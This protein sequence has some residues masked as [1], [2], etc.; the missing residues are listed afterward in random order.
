[1][2]LVFIFGSGAVG[3]M[4][5]G[6]ELMKLTGLRLFHNHMAIEPVL[7]V[8][9]GFNP[10]AVERIREAIFEEFAA[11]GQKGMIFTFMF[12]FDQQA[13]WDYVAHVQEIFRP[14]GT[15]FFYVELIAP[16]EVRL[17][18]SATENR[19]AHKASKQDVDAARS[20]LV[21]EDA[22]YRLVSL[23]G[24]IPWDNYL[25]IEN[26]HIPAAEAARMIRDRFGL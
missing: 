20:R 19:L 12:A 10:R 22:H 7:A 23:P 6:Q 9:G 14:Y 17:A 26:E 8:F 1:M 25:R 21:Q 24:E 4:T 15:E 13:D 3:K 11:S 16:Q 5:V 2:K 18:R